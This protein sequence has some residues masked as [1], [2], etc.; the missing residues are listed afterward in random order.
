MV[1]V[2]SAS[3]T[4]MGRG[5]ICL[6]WLLALGAI[7]KFVLTRGFLMDL[8]SRQPDVLEMN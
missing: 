2:S 1:V 7:A 3:R 6:S 4:R 8:D 5:G